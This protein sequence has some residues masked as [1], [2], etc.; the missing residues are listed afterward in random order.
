MNTSE[1][2][3]E[4]SCRLAIDANDDYGRNKSWEKLAEIL[5]KNVLEAMEFFQHEFTDEEFYWLSEIFEE[6]AEK[7]QSKELIQT[8]RDRLSKVTPENY[9]RQS[10][11]SEHMRK[12]VDYAEFVRSVGDEIDYAEGRIEETDS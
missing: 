12:W 6:V 5:S 11:H 1:L 3:N 8:L 10:F 4:L 9:D 7:T 2:R